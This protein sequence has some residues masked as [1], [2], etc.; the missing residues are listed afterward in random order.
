MGKIMQIVGAKV[1]E[2]QMVKLS[3]I[4]YTSKE[5]R[6]KKISMLDLA[7]KGMDTQ[8]MV[9]EIQGEQQQISILFISQDEWLNVF[10]NK[11]Y[12]TIKINMSIEKELP[13]R[14]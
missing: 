7:V 8:Q 6:K 11:L 10:K 2:N 12:T 1:V 4:P 3:L 14:R 5:V 9:K 13:S